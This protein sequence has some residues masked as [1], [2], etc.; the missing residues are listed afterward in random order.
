M[1]TK[2]LLLTAAISAAGLASSM[3]QVYSVNAVGY[4]NSSV[5]SHKLAILGSPLNGT[6]NNINTIMPLP[7]PGSD[8]VLV[9]RWDATASNFR[10]PIQWYDGFG[11]FSPSDD[12]PTINPGEG[13]WI[14]NTTAT[15]LN[16]TFVGE[17]PQGS[18]ATPVAGGN[19]L[20]LKSSQVPQTAQLGDTTINKPGSLEYPAADGDL[21]FIWD[22]AT[23][24]FKDP[25]QYYDGFGWFAAS[26]DEG[27][28]GPTIPVAT[29]FWSQ[30]PGAN[31]SWT[32][33]FSVN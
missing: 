10:D 28:K 5:P 23:Q 33:T 19:K 22:V 4:V 11:W 24:N 13:F 31:A 20:D 30:N 12:N 2:T 14:N 16:F 6:N 3:A 7:D 26:G 8:G 18:L 1:R 15:T 21:V 29:G 17:V 27:P 25:F 32:R 9:F